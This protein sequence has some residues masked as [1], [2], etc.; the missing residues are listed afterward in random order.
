VRDW[1]QVKGSGR[2]DAAA[3]SATMELLSVDSAGLDQLDRRI[4]LTVIEK[5][6]GGP[7]GV[8]TLAVSIS[9]ERETVE[10]VFEP[11][12]IQLGFLARTPRGRVAT[13]L[14][15]THLGLTPPARSDQPDLLT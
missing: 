12:L 3:V 15:Y 6:A 11:F 13:Q 2:I 7:V 8:D 5:Y 9:E 4:L 14:A 1:A 10:D